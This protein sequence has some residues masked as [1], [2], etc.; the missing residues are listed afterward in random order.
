MPHPFQVGIAPVSQ[1][2]DRRFRIAGFRLGN[3]VGQIITGLPVD[4]NN[5]QTA[6]EILRENAS[7]P[8]LQEGKQLI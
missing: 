1:D 2:N 6:H 3:A 7:F 8:A 5:G 4:E